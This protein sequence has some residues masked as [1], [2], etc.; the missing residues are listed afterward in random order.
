MRNVFPNPTRATVFFRV[1]DKLS[2]LRLHQQVANLSGQ[3]LID[4]MENYRDGSVDLGR[5][6]RGTYIL[7]LTSLDGRWQDTRRILKD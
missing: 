2:V 4:R 6:P 5:L 1:G 7:T 3:T